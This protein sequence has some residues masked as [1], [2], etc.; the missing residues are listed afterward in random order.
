MAAQ[1]N[2]QSLGKAT[3]P[4]RTKSS[5]YADQSQPRRA[6][7]YVHVSMEEQAQGHS[8]EE[9]E[10]RC[11]DFLA[12]EKPN[13]TLVKV[14]TDTHSGKTDRRPKFKELLRLIDEG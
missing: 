2:P 8:L 1:S 7:I 6:A 4:H 10:R 13:W 14:L 11:R 3:R 5:P 12:K 9:Q